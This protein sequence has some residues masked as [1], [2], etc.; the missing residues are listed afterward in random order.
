MDRETNDAVEL[1]RELE[2]SG[3]VSSEEIREAIMRAIYRLGAER[4]ERLASHFEKMGRADF[5]EQI[6]K[7]TAGQVPIDKPPRLQ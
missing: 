7:M 1:L 2:A 6:R 4:K 3:A 5:A